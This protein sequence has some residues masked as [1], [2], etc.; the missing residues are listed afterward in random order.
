MR[1][2]VNVGTFMPSVVTFKRS[3]VSFVYH[4]FTHQTKDPKDQFR[5]H[6]FVVCV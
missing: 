5:P 6:N 1:Y 2:S 4:M 3:L